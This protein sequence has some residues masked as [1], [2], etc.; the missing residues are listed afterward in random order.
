MPG[1]F[2]NECQKQLQLHVKWSH[3][4][5]VTKEE[6]NFSVTNLMMDSI[7]LGFLVAEDL[8]LSHVSYLSP[9]LWRTLLCTSRTHKLNLDS[10]L[11]IIPNPSE[12]VLDITETSLSFIMFHPDTTKRLDNLQYIAVIYNTT[13]ENIEAQKTNIFLT[14]MY[15]KRNNMTKFN[16]IKESKFI[17]K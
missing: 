7:W 3:D 14:I 1:N 12:H 5:W 2:N 16:Y 6:R 9:H 13:N 11:I 8:V 15:F 4:T 17:Y 10:T